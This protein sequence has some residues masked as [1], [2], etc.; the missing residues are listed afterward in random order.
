M[1][2]SACRR[3]AKRKK[4]K[5][6]AR[7]EATELTEYCR[8]GRALG[9]PLRALANTAIHLT[10]IENRCYEILLALRSRSRGK[11]PN[12][13]GLPKP[14]K[15]AIGREDCVTTIRCGSTDQKVRV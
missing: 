4:Q 14:L 13:D 9:F 7:T 10:Y 8:V 15:V 11:K 3:K 1:G 12:I 5:K 6:K 2:V